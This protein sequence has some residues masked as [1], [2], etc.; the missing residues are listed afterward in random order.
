MRLGALEILLI[1]GVILLFF[2]PSRLPGLGQSLGSAI[3][4]FKK[5]VTGDP[6]PSEPGDKP[7]LPPADPKSKA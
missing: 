6:D 3:R 5:G 2:G 1:L 7:A 4:S